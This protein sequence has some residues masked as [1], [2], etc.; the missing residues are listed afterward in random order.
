[1][2]NLLLDILKVLLD[3]R[4][5][6]GEIKANTDYCGSWLE[7]ITDNGLEAAFAAAGLD[8]NS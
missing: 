7:M 2:P 3:I 8:S 4:G 6:L 5:C 1:V